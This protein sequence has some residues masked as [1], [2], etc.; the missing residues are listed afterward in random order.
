MSETKLSYSEAIHLGS[1]LKPQ[2]FGIL[3]A[4]GTACAN[5]AARLAVGKER[6]E[7]LMRCVFTI[8]GLISACPVCGVFRPLGS[9]VAMCLNDAHRWPLSRIADWVETIERE[10]AEAAERAEPH[11]AEIEM[12]EEIAHA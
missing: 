4:P 7:E 5:D 8:C 3:R 12:L 6:T 2:G 1:M 10:Q 9:V 11:C